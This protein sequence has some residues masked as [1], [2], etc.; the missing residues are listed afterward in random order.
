MPGRIHKKTLKNKDDQT[1]LIRGRYLSCRFPQKRQCSCYNCLLKRLRRYT[2]FIVVLFCLFLKIYLVA[3]L[4]LV[5]MLNSFSLF[6][7]FRNRQTT[8]ITENVYNNLKPRTTQLKRGY[9]SHFSLSIHRESF[10]FLWVEEIADSFTCI[11]AN[12]VCC[13]IVRRAQPEWHS[14]AQVV[15]SENVRCNFIIMI[16]LMIR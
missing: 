9:F 16:R 3:T 7:T 11:F 14:V 13:I 4:S 8:G 5:F 1:R 12:L 6:S 15:D 2:S 10:S